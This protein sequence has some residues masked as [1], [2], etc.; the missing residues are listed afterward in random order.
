MLLALLILVPGLLGGAD[1][2]PALPFDT[3]PLIDGGVDSSPDAGGTVPARSPIIPFA[4]AD[5]LF[6]GGGPAADIGRGAEVGPGGPAGLAAADT[7]RRGP[8]AFGGG[9]V[10][11]AAGVSSAPAF[12]LIQRFSSGSY[13]N[14]EASPS[15]AR[16]GLFGCEP[17]SALSFLALALNQPPRPQ[18]LFFGCISLA[19]AAARRQ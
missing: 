9:G 6:D 17:A 12:L 1:A 11:A 2:P 3:L 4:N 18:P 10:A 15:F 19:R 13:T 16:I 14:D 7:A 8:V 5:R